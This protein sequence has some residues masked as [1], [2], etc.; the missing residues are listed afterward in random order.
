M[1][2]ALLG[3]LGPRAPRGA[4]QTAQRR[5]APQGG[6]RASGTAQRRVGQKSEPGDLH[7]ASATVVFLSLALSPSDVSDC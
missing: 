4:Q 3:P 1:A 6:S 2:L 5:S 7:Q